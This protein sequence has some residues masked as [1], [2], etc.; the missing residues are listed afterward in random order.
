LIESE[1]MIY[2]TQACP[3]VRQR[4]ASTAAGFISELYD[5]LVELDKH[6]GSRVEQCV[7]ES[8][9]AGEGVAKLCLVCFTG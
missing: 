4:K 2:A 1:L 8:S 3:W 5:V 7:D 6:L 9:E